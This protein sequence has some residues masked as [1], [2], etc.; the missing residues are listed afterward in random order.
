MSVSPIEFTP[1][2]LVKI[3][4][5]N[6]IERMYTFTHKSSYNHTEDD[7]TNTEQKISKKNTML[8]NK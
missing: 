4:E 5:Q 2:P 8:M 3:K 1:Q 7:N 6:D